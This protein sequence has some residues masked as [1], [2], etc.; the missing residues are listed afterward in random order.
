[1]TSVTAFNQAIGGLAVRN[2]NVTLLAEMLHRQQVADARAVETD[3]APKPPPR[4]AD[5][6]GKGGRLDVVA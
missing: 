2:L 1:M 6:P 5:E 4:G 3:A